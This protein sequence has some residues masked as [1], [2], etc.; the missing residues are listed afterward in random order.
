MAGA[1]KGDEVYANLK[2]SSGGS[3]MLG[4]L[5]ML[6]AAAISAYS[7][8][9]V[10]D[11]QAGYNEDA[12]E[13]QNKLQKDYALWSA[14]NV[15]QAQMAGYKRAGLNPILAVGKDTA[16]SANVT[17]LPAVAPDY[18][19]AAISGL[20][21]ALEAYNTVRSNARADMLAESQ[22]ALNSAKAVQAGFDADRILAD[23]KLKAYQLKN[24]KLSLVQE[25]R[26]AWQDGVGSAFESSAQ[27]VFDAWYNTP[28]S[29]RQVVNLAIDPTGL[30]SKAVKSFGNS[31]PS[32]FER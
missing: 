27:K 24:P 11:A 14:Q 2:G 32:D 29:V 28:K 19:K 21:T 7:A 25:L 23:T 12:M 6:G 20:S 17:A 30:G 3:S 1:Y 5:A 31:V 8:S 18:G 22:A 16:G 15:P 26:K 4:G 9:Q 13:L 10:A